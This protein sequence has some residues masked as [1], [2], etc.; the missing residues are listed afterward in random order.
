MFEKAKV[1]VTQAYKEY[2]D[3]D[4][5][6]ALLE[7]FR[8]ITAI[9]SQFEGIPIPALTH[10]AQ[11][12]LGKLRDV[13]NGPRASVFY[14]VSAILRIDRDSPEVARMMHVES[15][16]QKTKRSGA[17]P[18]HPADITGHLDDED[19]EDEARARKKA[20]GKG[21]TQPGPPPPPT[22]KYGPPPCYRWVTGHCVGATCPVKPAKRTGPHPHAWNPR[23]VGTAA[24][25]EFTAFCIKWKDN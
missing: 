22:L 19:E 2:F 23:D 5:K 9:H 25:K 6:I 10:L 11:V 18:R 12:T 15:F 4:M 7:Y 14:D 21:S 16:G 8:S 20:K 1:N 3:D 17:L 13:K 24:Q